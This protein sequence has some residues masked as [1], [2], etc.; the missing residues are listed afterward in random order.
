MVGMRMSWV[1]FSPPTHGFLGEQPAAHSQ[2]WSTQGK[3]LSPLGL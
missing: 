3:L 1:H 2:P